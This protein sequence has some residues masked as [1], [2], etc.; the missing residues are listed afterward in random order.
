MHGWKNHTSKNI[1]AAKFGIG[2][3][4]KKTLKRT[5]S[6]VGMKGR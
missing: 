5:Q 1:W 3:I 6:W 2:G 4:K